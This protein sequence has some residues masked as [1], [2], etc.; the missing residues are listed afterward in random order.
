MSGSEHRTTSKRLPTGNDVVRR[1]CF[2]ERPDDLLEEEFLVER[3]GS[4]PLR[5]TGRLIGANAID[6]D[7]PRGTSVRVFV[8]RSA[9]IVTS[10]RQWQRG[11]GASRERNAA[12]VHETPAEALAWLVEDGRGRLGSASCEAWRKACAAWPAL[13]EHGAEEID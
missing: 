11:R 5:F 1:T 2:P 3:D 8:T 12:A 10:V 7:V 6:E 13:R 4:L 9:K